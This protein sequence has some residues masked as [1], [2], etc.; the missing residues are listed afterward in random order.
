MTIGEKIRLMRKSRKWTQTEL[1]DKIG[2]S[3]KVISK[4]EKGIAKPKMNSITKLTEVLGVN[5]TYFKPIKAQVIPLQVYQQ[6][7]DGKVIFEYDE[8]KRKPRYKNVVI[9]LIN[10]DV[11]DDDVSKLSQ[12]EIDEKY[13]VVEYPE[14]EFFVIKRDFTD[15][16]DGKYYAVMH[17]SEIICE[18]LY[19]DKNGKFFSVK[20]DSGGIVNQIAKG[21]TKEKLYNAIEKNNL[22]DKRTFGSGDRDQIAGVSIAKVMT[23]K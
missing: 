8:W 22:I 17:G 18:K 12:D 15:I 10:N 16:V 1:G 4:W 11:F 7:K 14:N 13:F 21:N 20:V 9:D 6:V 19:N 5:E 2:V 3:N 23:I